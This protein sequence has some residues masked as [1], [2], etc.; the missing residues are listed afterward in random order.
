M[1]SLKNQEVIILN[2]IYQVIEKE[3]NEIDFEKLTLVI[4]FKQFKGNI[5]IFLLNIIKEEQ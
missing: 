1:I 4:C 5:W 3:S 2:D